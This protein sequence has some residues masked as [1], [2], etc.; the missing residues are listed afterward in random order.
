MANKLP[1]RSASLRRNDIVEILTQMGW[2]FKPLFDQAHWCGESSWLTLET[3]QTCIPNAS[4]IDM[5]VLMEQ[6]RVKASEHGFARVRQ[7]Q[8][9]E[10][11][12]VGQCA[13]TCYFCESPPY[14]CNQ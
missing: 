9:V 5:T 3:I 2:N 6:G 1:D 8:K 11:V 12:K 4:A 10:S 7:S 13:T 14:R